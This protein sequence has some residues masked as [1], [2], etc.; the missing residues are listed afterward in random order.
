MIVAAI[1][2]AASPVIGLERFRIVGDAIPEPLGGLT[3]NAGRGERIVRDRE[4]GNCLICHAVRDPN[5]RFQ[6]ELGPP[7]DGVGARL[8][9]GQIRLR[10]VDQS[11]LNEATLMPPYYRVEGLT[12]VA[13]PYRGKPVLSAQ[14]IEDVVAYLA[15]LKE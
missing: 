11:R 14:E 3:G 5:E 2:A 8:G 9:E 6:G 13:P 4:T 1:A 7:L 12:W 15:S 10:L